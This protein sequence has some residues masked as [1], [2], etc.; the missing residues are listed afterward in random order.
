MDDGRETV[1]AHESLSRSPLVTGDR[2]EAV[3]THDGGGWASLR[4]PWEE[5]P[6]M[7][8]YWLADVV[9]QLDGFLGRRDV[10]RVS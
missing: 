6:E 9:W 8:R 2:R 3:G 5:L 1:R 10:D 4:G 7:R